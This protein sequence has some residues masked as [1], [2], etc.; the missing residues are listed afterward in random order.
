MSNYQK[1]HHKDGSFT[2]YQQIHSKKDN[3]Q[4]IIFLSGFKSDMNGTKAQAFSKYA[5][6][7]NLDLTLFEYSGHG[8]SS[9]K[10][11]DG[12][13]GLWLENTLNVIDQLTEKPQIL[14]GSS[15]GGWIMLLAAL[16]R[17]ER[18]SSL[19]GLAAAPDFTEEL[20]WDYLTQEQKDMLLK[21][22]Q[23]DFNNEFCD[24]PYPISL[25]LITEA[26]EHILL[27]KEII[28][29]MP[30]HLIHGM[31]DKD[32]PYQTSIRIAEK[33]TSSN[34]NVHLIKDADHVLSRPQD[35]EFIY[36]ILAKELK[37]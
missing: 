30:I 34:V 11:T 8:S 9:G 26:R 37:K 31:E 6:K 2:T 13:I 21:N 29:D 36:D 12:T 23:I 32:V 28:L 10:F 14:V 27:D 33:V 7:N 3:K 5:K 20:I 25:D 17:P 16:A 19:I 1:L 15:M 22:K 35:L 18:I 4:G 24:D